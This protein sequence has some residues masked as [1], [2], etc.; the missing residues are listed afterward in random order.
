MLQTCAEL[1]PITCAVSVLPLRPSNAPRSPLILER[2]C[3]PLIWRLEGTTTYDVFA[4]ASW[5][6]APTDG[7]EATREAA[8]E[9]FA[10][11]WRQV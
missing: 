7:Y 4:D 5:Y 2:E 9:A 1:L 3:L 8:M 11:S 10:K 6:G